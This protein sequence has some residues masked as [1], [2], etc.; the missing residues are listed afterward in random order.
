MRRVLFTA[1]LVLAGLGAG[2][3][4]WRL[5]SVS[6]GDGRQAPGTVPDTRLGQSSGTSPGILPRGTAGQALPTG[7][8]SKSKEIA[9]LVDCRGRDLKPHEKELLYGLLRDPKQPSDLEPLHL[10]VLKNNILNRLRNE[11]EAS[12]EVE[13]VMVEMFENRDQPAVLRDYAIQHLACWYADGHPSERVLRALTQALSEIDSSIAG[14]ALLGLADLAD[15]YPE[16]SADRVAQAAYEIAASPATGELSKI[17][18][19]RVG[20]KLKIDALRETAR[21]LA[22]TGSTI[23]LRIAAIATLGDLPDPQALSFLQSLEGGPD[24][25]LAFAARSALD[26]S[27]PR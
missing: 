23:P 27:V 12:I 6:E 4:F 7:D 16:V 13:T 24:P 26:R 14:T 17:A 20:G 10:Y 9:D 18:A 8:G 1:L 25:R 3:Q 21:E 15:S 2:L 22:Q 19:L 5:K 11:P